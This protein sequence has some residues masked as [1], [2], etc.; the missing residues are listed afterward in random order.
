MQKNVKTYDGKESFISAVLREQTFCYLQLRPQ[1]CEQ[2]PVL[3]KEK[4]SLIATLPG[5]KNHARCLQNGSL[6]CLMN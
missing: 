5:L 3:I 4:A 2:V 1:A 6:M